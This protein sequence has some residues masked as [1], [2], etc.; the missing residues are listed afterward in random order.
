[1]LA[2]GLAVW[3]APIAFIALDGRQPRSGALPAGWSLRVHRGTAGV[4]TTQGPEGQVLHFVSRSSSFGVERG[5]DVDPGQ[6]PYLIWNWKV[7]ELPR[8]G[9]FRRRSTDDQAAQVLLLFSD[10]RILSYVWESSAPQ[11]SIQKGGAV[12]V[13]F[14]VASLACRSGAAELNRWIR[15]ARNV[16]EDFR[17]S[18]GRNATR[19]RGLRLQIN[20]QHT[21]TSAESWFGE[22]AF[23]PALD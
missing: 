2:V 10:R 8:G 13:L 3:G 4:E 23:R 17:R 16:P 14:D 12:P 15:E 20:T 9:D 19:V 18:F 22:V 6:L 1:M 5:L 11:G 7:T 21:G